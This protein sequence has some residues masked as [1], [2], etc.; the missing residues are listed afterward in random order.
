MRVVAPGRFARGGHGVDEALTTQQHRVE[1]GREFFCRLVFHGPAGRDHAAHADLDQRFGNVGRE[2]GA[3]VRLQR[4]RR[5]APGQ[6]TAVE[7]HELGHDTHRLDLGRAEEGVARQHHAALGTELAVAGHVHHA[8]GA[9]EQGVDDAACIVITA[10][11]RA[12]FGGRDAV[13]AARQPRRHGDGFGAC[14]GQRRVGRV[15]GAGLADHEHAVVGV[16]V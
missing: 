2:G 15:V 1:G 3:V 14:A 7:E 5:V 9:L 16:R 6:V 12:Q 8:V 4:A 10:D 11:E 13:G